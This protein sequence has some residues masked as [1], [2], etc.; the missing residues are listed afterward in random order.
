MNLP[1]HPTILLLVVL[2]VIGAA[3]T[4]A[5]AETFTFAGTTSGGNTVNGT[6]TFSAG[7]SSNLLTIVITNNQQNI[8]TTGQAISGLSFQVKDAQGN[9]LNIS[10]VV[11]MSQTGREV[12]FLGSQTGVDVNGSGDDALGWGLSNQNPAY[13]N[14]LG[15]TGAN[16]TNPP[17]E[18]ILGSP[19]STNAN[20]QVVYSSANSSISNSGPHQPFVVS[21][22]TFSVQ[23]ALNLPPGFQIVNVQMYF[24]T[25]ADTLTTQTPEPGSM[26]LLGTGLLGFAADVRRR[27]AMHKSKMRRTSTGD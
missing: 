15:F 16:G 8:V 27:Y 13:L 25:N 22:A 24:G 26:L 6:A 3:E 2:V 20:G 9:L 19:T 14:A 7:G 23:V 4:S 18:L 11:I 17:D 5:R 21:T 12:K 1:L 10:P